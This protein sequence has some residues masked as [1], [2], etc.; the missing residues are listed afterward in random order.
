MA[1]ATSAYAATYGHPLEH[2]TTG[3]PVRWGTSARTAL[4]VAGALALVGAGVVVH[5][6]TQAPAAV[7]LAEPAVPEPPADAAPQ[8]T[9][10][11]DPTE[12]TEPVD[13]AARTAGQ[14]VLVHVVGRVHQ[15]G[16]VELPAGSRVVDAVTAAG[17]ATTE[18]DL[19][20]LNLARPVVD[21]EQVVV[22]RPGE[23]VPPVDVAGPAPPGAPGP[24]SGVTDLNR[25]SVAELEALPGIGPV[26]ASRIVAHRDQHGPFA[27][28]DDLQAVRG[29]GPALLADLRPLVGP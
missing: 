21:G 15:P 23:D 25:A 3:G 9:D 4:L 14:V 7:V 2:A 8:P 16:V 19:S 10:A 26:L 13:D 27:S 20:G 5:A 22:P 6:L 28:V 11:T 18:A 12:A 29:I 17:G 1:A 24:A